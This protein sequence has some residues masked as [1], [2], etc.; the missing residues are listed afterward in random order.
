MR[1]G[2]ERQMQA[3]QRETETAELER[4]ETGMQ[5]AL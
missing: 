2:Q 3:W 4:E 1:E 5:A